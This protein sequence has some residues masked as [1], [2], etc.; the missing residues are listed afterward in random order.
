LLNH[1]DTIRWRQAKRPTW[2]PRVRPDGSPASK[3]GVESEQ[4]IG[5]VDGVYDLDC[6]RE[7]GPVSVRAF[8][9]DRDL[10][11]LVP[12]AGGI[13]EWESALFQLLGLNHGGPESSIVLD[14]EANE[15]LVPD[16]LPWWRTEPAQTKS[17]A[18][19]P[20]VA[21]E[22]LATASS[23]GSVEVVEGS[24][25]AYIAAFDALAGVGDWRFSP[26]WVLDT[27][28][29]GENTITQSAAHAAI[30]GWSYEGRSGVVVYVFGGAFND[31]YGITGTPQPLHSYVLVVTRT[32]DGRDAV[33]AVHRITLSCPG[34]HWCH[35]GGCPE[36]EFSE[37]LE[38]EGM[39]GPVTSS[40]QAV[41]RIIDSAHAS[42]SFRVLYGGLE[43]GAVADAVLDVASFLLTD[44]GWQELVESEWEGGLEERLFQRD[45]HILEVGYDPTTRQFLLRDG[46]GSI[47]GILDLFSEDGVLIGEAETVGIDSDR[48]AAAG[49]RPG[50]VDAIGTYLRGEIKD[51][52]LSADGPQ[53]S[54]IGLHPYSDGTLR[55]P[56]AGDLIESQLKAF[57]SAEGIVG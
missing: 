4:A 8:A 56:D 3:A 51:L 42:E 48:A 43:G 33:E 36:R 24:I 23:V 7:I 41:R 25:E 1:L 46:K 44:A 31:T 19:D 54:V 15:A 5:F 47:E 52:V 38:L 37:S 9:G 29:P 34:E 22:L 13:G 35:R 10:P 30:A 2:I 14:A 27:Y 28:D 20:G 53:M 57:L 26:R 40:V 55:G 6:L 18:E 16:E 39:L 21:G 32:A 50:Q 17:A 49:W 45:E 12:S 11:R